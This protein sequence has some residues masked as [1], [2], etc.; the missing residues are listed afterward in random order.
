MRGAETESRTAE[1]TTNTAVAMAWVDGYNA[2]EEGW[3]DRFYAEEVSLQT[4][5]PWSPEGVSAN[6]SQ[7]EKLI[8]EAARMYPD[9]T[10]KVRTL[11]AEGD[12]VVMETEW[13]GTPAPS[14]PTLQSSEPQVLRNIVFNRFRDGRI[15]ETR[16]FGVLVSGSADWSV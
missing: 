15:F 13:V 14:H 3:F 8:A 1:E 12:T 11:V 9:R 16:E 6:R 2:Q 10:M 7:L 5:G 4:Y